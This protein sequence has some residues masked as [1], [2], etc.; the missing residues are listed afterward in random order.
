MRYVKAAAKLDRSCSKRKHASHPA[1]KQTLVQQRSIPS[2]SGLLVCKND[3][4]YYTPHRSA[5]F[6]MFFP[7][8]EVEESRAWICIASCWT[9]SSFFH[10][11]Q[12]SGFLLEVRYW[13]I[14][15]SPS[16]GSEPAWLNL[17]FSSLANSATFRGDTAT[18]PPTDFAGFKYVT[19]P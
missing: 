13:S 10:S 17:P 12:M 1:R 16:K 15:I 7:E 8:P 4:T 5:S 9:L 14:Q 11:L 19:G 3:Y 6:L 2:T 18:S